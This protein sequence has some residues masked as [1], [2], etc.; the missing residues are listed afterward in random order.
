[1]YII[2]IDFEK[3]FGSLD[4]NFMLKSLDLFGFGPSLIRWIETFYTDISSCV[5]NNGLST[6]YFQLERE[7]RQGDPLSPYLFI[8]TVE[9]LAIAIPSWTDIHGIKIGKAEEF[10]IVQYADDLTAF[11]SNVES[12]QRIFQLLDQ[13]RSCSGLKVNYTKT[14]GMWIGSCRENTAA[15]LG[16]K[17]CKRVKASG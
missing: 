16:L 9:I 6:S 5:I 3:A 10:K 17:W 7:V 13:F 11:V 8:V 12:A 15:P 14:E 4:W 1:M 2:F